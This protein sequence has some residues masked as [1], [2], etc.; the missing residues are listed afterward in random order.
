MNK[1]NDLIRDKNKRAYISHSC[2]YENEGLTTN[3]DSKSHVI[4]D[5]LFVNG[6]FGHYYLSHSDAGQPYDSPCI[7]AGANTRYSLLFKEMTTRIDGK[8][9]INKIDIGYHYHVL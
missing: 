6:P 9:D 8:T 4:E 3:L 2:M 5:P 7:D 1:G